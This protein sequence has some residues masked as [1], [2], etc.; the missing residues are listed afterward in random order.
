MSGS[1]GK[2]KA[3]PSSQMF[4]WR[5][6]ATWQPLVSELRGVRQNQRSMLLALRGTY[7]SVVG[8]H[9]GRPLDVGS[10]YSQGLRIADYEQLTA[11]AKRIFMSPEFPEINEGAFQEAVGILSRGFGHEIH[12]GASFVALDDRR[13]LD[14]CGHYLI[15]GSERICGIAAQLGRNRI[16]DYRQVLKRFGI[17]TIFRISLPLAMIAESDL[18]ELA[19]VV[20][21]WVPRIRAGRR[22]RQIDFTFQL[23]RDIPAKHILGHEHPTRIRDPLLHMQPIYIYPTS[24]AS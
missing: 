17:P 1:K 7:D 22:P 21:E 6:T 23:A 18:L 9:G 24:P 16:K 20:R 10:Y 5:D 3:T 12:N 13:L 19:D 11:T 14:H 2:L 4:V 15:Y 8:F